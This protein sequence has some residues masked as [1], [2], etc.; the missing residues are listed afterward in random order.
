MRMDRTSEADFETHRAALLA[1]AYRMLGDLARAEDMVQEAWLRWQA[2]RA[3]VESPRAYL[4]TIVTRLCLDELGSPRARKEES[5][6]DRL[7]EPV[8]LNES[9]LDRLELLDQ[10]SMAFLVVLQRLTPAERAV[11]LLH[12]VFEM[13]HDEIAPLVGKSDAACRQLL[14][15]ARG[16]VAA[17]RRVLQGR[18]EDHRRLLR[19]FVGA[20]SGGDP[21]PLVELLAEDVVLIGDGGQGERRYGKIRKVGRPVVG[22][23][24]VAALI[25]AIGAQPAPDVVVEE[26]V[27]NGQPAI[28]LFQAG[29]AVLAILVAVADGRIRQLF[30]HADPERLRR[31]QPLH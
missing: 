28:V 15:R 21:A 4:I 30:L 3:A 5:R 9:G 17:E 19:A 7:P 6:A 29:E 24:R 1:L 23:T 10:V 22:K 20:I 13:R 25:R 2:R 8:D 18:P 27:L 12:E 14:S 31:L 16:H 11:F 26:R